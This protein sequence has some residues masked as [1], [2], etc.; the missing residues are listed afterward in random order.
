MPVSYEGELLRSQ[1]LRDE[2]A[3]I[4]RAAFDA[5]PLPDKW[6]VGQIV[7]QV[8]GEGLGLPRGTIAYVHRLSDD[9][10][11]K[12]ATEYQVFWIGPKDKSST[13]WTTPADVELVEDCK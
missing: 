10:A 9:C 3:K 5:R 8:R 2:A 13:W 6:R 12:A 1:A 7:R 4:E 11:S